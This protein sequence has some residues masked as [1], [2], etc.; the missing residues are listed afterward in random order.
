M[1]T[2]WKDCNLHELIGA[3]YALRIFARSPHLTKDA[4]EVLV[5][6]IN[7]VRAEINAMPEECKNVDIELMKDR[8]KIISG[9]MIDK[10]KNNISCSTGN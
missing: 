3:D 2:C 7:E 4:R 10:Q 5:D 8:D 1:S 9:I 6:L